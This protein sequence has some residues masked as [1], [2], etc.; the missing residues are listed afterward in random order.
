MEIEVAE[1]GADD[2]SVVD[3]LR[4]LLPA[5]DAL[6]GDENCPFVEYV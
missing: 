4:L 6:F 2:I 1:L 3:D 5:L